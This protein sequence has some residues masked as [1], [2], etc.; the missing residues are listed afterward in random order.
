MGEDGNLFF[1]NNSASHV[2]SSAWTGKNYE[3]HFW[4]NIAR[5]QAYLNQLW[6]YSRDVFAQVF[7]ASPCGMFISH[8]GSGSFVEVNDAFCTLT[9]FSREMLLSRGMPLF[10]MWKDK[11]ERETLL[12]EIIDRGSMNNREISFFDCAGIKHSALLS[13]SLLHLKEQICLL[14]V[15]NDISDHKEAAGDA[16]RLADMHLLSE[17]AVSLAHEVRSPMTTVRGF[18]QIMSENQQYK[19]DGEDIELMIS[20]IDKANSII[21]EVLALAREK[22]LDLQNHD[23]NLLLNSL[24]PILTDCALRQQ[25]KLLFDSNDKLVILMDYSE[26][27]QLIVKLVQNA[28]EAM[29]PGQTLLLASFVREGEILFCG[30]GLGGPEKING[31]PSEARAPQPL[32]NSIGWG[33]TLCHSIA[34]RHHALLEINNTCQGEIFRLRFRK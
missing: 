16:N 21:S 30:E 7:Y 18:L 19:L 5:D 31:V 10:R 22:E 15:M 27:K 17:L 25:K 26:I 23:F 3:H 4:Q 2:L 8:L 6:R 12:R 28:L 34:A 33:N 1:S 24:A 14:S 32:G 20:E 9:G 29:I 13:T 11:L